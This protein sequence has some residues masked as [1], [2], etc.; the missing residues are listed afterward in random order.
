MLNG[1][2][3][4]KQPNCRK[5]SGRKKDEAESCTIGKCFFGG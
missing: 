4:N 1:K 5:I 3:Q 2:R